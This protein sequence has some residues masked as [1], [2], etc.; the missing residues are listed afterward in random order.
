[1]IPKDQSSLAVK[2][3]RLYFYQALTTEAI[4]RELGLSRPAVSRL[5]TFAR[6]SGL[7]RNPRA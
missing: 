2:V 5:L 7:R 6:Q 1:M 4:A 3:A